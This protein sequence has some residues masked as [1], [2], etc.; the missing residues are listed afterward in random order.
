MKLDSN[1]NNYLDKE[2]QQAVEEEEAEFEKEVS[3]VHHDSD[4]DFSQE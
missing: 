3:Q 1:K 4:L 2:F